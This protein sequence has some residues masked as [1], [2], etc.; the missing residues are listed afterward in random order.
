MVNVIAV[1]ETIEQVHMRLL[2]VGVHVTIAASSS[3]GVGSLAGLVVGKYLATGQI[4]F[5][6]PWLV[7]VL[8]FC[9]FCLDW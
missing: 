7:L 3:L 9:A 4:T 1:A 2:F 8:A 6:A 5:P